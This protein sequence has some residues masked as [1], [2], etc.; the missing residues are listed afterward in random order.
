M[1][2]QNSFYVA[3]R[4]FASELGRG[5]WVALGGTRRRVQRQE[6]GG[7]NQYNSTSHAW[8]AWY[9]VEGY[10]TSTC[11]SLKVSNF[12]F[13]LALS[14]AVGQYKGRPRRVDDPWLR[15]MTLV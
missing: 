7:S 8:W 14:L 9:G 2:A 10:S 3:M 15:L 6:Q 13:W 11:G 12:W 4:I 1:F 5:L